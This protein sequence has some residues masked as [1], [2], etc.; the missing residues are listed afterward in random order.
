MS[1]CNNKRKALDV[2]CGKGRMYSL[3]AN[4]DFSVTGIDVSESLLNI[5]KQN[6]PSAQWLLADVCTWNPIN[7]Y[8]L[9][10][11]WD[12][13]FHVPHDQQMEVHQKLCKS[14][15]EGGVI[16]F[17]AGGRDGKI[18]G[19]MHG[20]KFDYSS[21]DTDEYLKIL[22]NAGCR[23]VLIERDQFPADH[24]VVIGIKD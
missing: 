21:L 22:K 8:D 7:A 10:V 2:G 5:T 13:T 24:V 20:E 11:A 23:C 3:L 16:L 1:Y 12:S 17:T 9:I 14:L 15:A 4:A 19:T 18:S 6:H